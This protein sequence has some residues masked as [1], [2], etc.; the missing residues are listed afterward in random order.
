MGCLF[1]N[2]CVLGQRSC[3]PCRGDADGDRD[4][5]GSQDRQTE[6]A[7]KGLASAK[8]NGEGVE[9]MELEVGLPMQHSTV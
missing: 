5:Q 2:F 7:D 4:G 3:S 6:A 1:S 9:R 8:D